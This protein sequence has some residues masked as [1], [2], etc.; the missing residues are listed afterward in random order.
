MTTVNSS[1]APNGP[2][3]RHVIRVLEF[4]E[5]CMAEEAEREGI[6]IE[7]VR[8]R[9]LARAEERQRKM[10]QNKKASQK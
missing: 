4:I 2:T 8:A 5:Q 10:E 7:D 6:P 9:A 1:P 3:S